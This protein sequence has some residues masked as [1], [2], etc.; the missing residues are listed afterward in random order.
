MHEWLAHVLGKC[1]QQRVS[2]KQQTA[3]LKRGREKQDKP[4][5]RRLALFSHSFS[6]LHLLPLS[7]YLYMTSDGK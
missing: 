1:E 7:V 2:P 6:L 5:I 4:P 3:Q